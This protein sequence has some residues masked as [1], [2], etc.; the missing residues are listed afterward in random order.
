MK[1]QFVKY[2]IATSI[3][4][5]VGCDKESDPSFEI[6][7]DPV[8]HK[9][10]K[11]EV[12]ER[13][14]QKVRIKNTENSS[15]A[16]VG[17]IV[18]MDSPAF[19]MDFSGV[20]TLEKNE[21]KEIYITFKPTAAMEYSGKLLIKNDYVLKEMYLYG[22]GVAP[23]SFT[24]DQSK[25]EFGL[26]KSGEAKD[27]DIN[28][29]NSASSGFDLELTLS[30]PSS[31]FSIVGGQTS[32]VVPPGQS[33]TTTIRYTPT[34]SSSSKSLKINHNSTVK[35]NPSTI[36]L[37]G[38]M[39]ESSV[40]INKISDGWTQFESSD[41]SGSR[42]SFQD[43]MNKGRI[44]A[45]YDSLYGEAMG[46]RGWAV[47]YNTS[48]SSRGES[49]YIDFTNAI[50][51]YGAIIASNSKLDMLAG[52][53]ISGALIGGSTGVYSAVISAAKTVL[54]E[55]NY[56]SFSH[57]TSVDHKDVRMA[58]IQGHYYLGE[59]TEAASEMDVLNPTNAPHSS[60]PGTLLAAI[61][62]LA[63]SL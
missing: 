25:L 6:T 30:I 34:V 45:A 43:A 46:G 47:L 19:T 56:Y 32:L 3:L 13:S 37:T 57:K 50:S 18:I 7:I 27:L 51:G 49:A 29:S 20:L 11:V 48:L 28:F 14:V 40:I 15:E 58:K 63:G 21:S 38:I 4:F 61:Q 8:E 41:Y 42:Q 36:Q 24:I 39:D 59:Y 54:T 2:F 62:A 5:I 35:P 60:D 31:D 16:F 55:N 23:V 44:H 9:Y 53:A 22:E 1:M 12:N 26:V 52:L 17:E 10:G 33:Q